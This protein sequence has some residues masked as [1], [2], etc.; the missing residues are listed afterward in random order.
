[1]INTTIKPAFSPKNTC[2]KAFSG[3]A[4]PSIPVKRSANVTGKA[5][6]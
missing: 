1:M 2:Y 3:T 5:Y 6:L 4:L